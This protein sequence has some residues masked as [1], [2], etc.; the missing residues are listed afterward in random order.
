MQLKS[1]MTRRTQAEDRQ[2]MR[3][4]LGGE[5]PCIEWRT[6]ITRVKT[7]AS[8]VVRVSRLT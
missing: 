2:T 7:G 3:E 8:R 1:R 5:N 6:I 4:I